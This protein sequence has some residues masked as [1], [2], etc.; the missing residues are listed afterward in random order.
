MN[1][2]L[3]L[4]SSYWDYLDCDNEYDCSNIIATCDG[5]IVAATKVQ[6]RKTI[7]TQGCVCYYI[8]RTIYRAMIND[9]KLVHKDAYCVYKELI[10]T[11]KPEFNTTYQGYY[12]ETPYNNVNL[13]AHCKRTEVFNTL[14][15]YRLLCGI[16]TPL[17]PCNIFSVEPSIVTYRRVDDYPYRMMLHPEFAKPWYNPTINQLIKRGL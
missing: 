10:D 16:Q 13:Y 17:I 8:N 11:L 5:H 1:M 4:A 3:R 15:L 9:R 12:P 2:I 14:A 6:Y 7:R